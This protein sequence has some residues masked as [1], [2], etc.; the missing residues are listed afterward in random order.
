MS[1]RTCSI[2]GC[3]RP[4]LA[5]TWCKKHYR[6][7]QEHGDPLGTKLRTKEERFRAK[8]EESDTG[9]WIWRAFVATN[10]YGRFWDGNTREWAHRASYELFVGPIPDGMQIDHLCHSEDE[11]CNSSSECPHRACV[12]P[13]HLEVV[14]QREN[15][16]RSRSIMAELARQTHCKNG[17]EFTA[18]N[19]HMTRRGERICRT[20]RREYA[21]ITKQRKK[22][23]R[24]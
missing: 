21:R 2:D 17:H 8:Y 5:R 3:E 19:T 23:E 4:F 18:A 7:W 22:A 10:G 1:K 15:N 13:D 11:S 24:T 9:C 6:A 14:T 20:C 12:N 16:L